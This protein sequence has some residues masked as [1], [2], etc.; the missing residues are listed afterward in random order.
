MNYKHILLRT[1]VLLL[2][3]GA[4]EAI[5]HFD[6]Y[7]SLIGATSISLNNFVFPPLFY[8]WLNKDNGKT[9]GLA[10]KTFFAEMVIF[11]VISALAGTYSSVEN[12]IAKPTPDPC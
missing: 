2:C 12:I 11:G 9:L 1:V 3:L 4:A 5:P 10:Q 7:I 8:Y 6:Q